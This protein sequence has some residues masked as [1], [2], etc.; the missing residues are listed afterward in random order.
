[1]KPRELFNE[2]KRIALPIQSVCEVGVYFADKCALKMFITAKIPAT[3]IE[4]D[5]AC[6]EDLKSAYGNLPSVQIIPKAIWHE[7]TQLKFY[8]SNASTFAG[9][10]GGS[11]AVINDSYQLR[12]QDSFA[13]DTVLFSDVD[14]GNFDL[15][16]IDVEGAEYNVLQHMKSRPKVLSLEI[17]ASSYQ[18][19]RLHEIQN[20][21]RENDYKLWFHND[22]DSVFIR[23]NPSFTI[24]Q[25]FYYGVL[26][27]RTNWEQGYQKQKKKIRQLLKIKH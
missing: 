25:K 7:R 4:A 22:T 14:S 20:W 18:N 16:L 13:V 11:P 27:F 5:P 21:L 19:P 9:A 12:D 17:R 26:N 1:M 10:V 23:G 2:V 15:V 24:S 8:R 6:I 3:L